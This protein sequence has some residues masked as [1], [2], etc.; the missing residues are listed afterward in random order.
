MARFLGNDTDAMG[1]GDREAD[2]LRIWIAYNEASNAGDHVTAARYIADDLAVMING[3]PA[4]ASAD[5][6][7]A[8]QAE[9]LRCY[10]DYT[11]DYLAGAVTPDGAVVEWCMHGTATADIGLPPLDVSGCSIVRCQDGRMVE[12]RLYHPTGV[13]DAVADQARARA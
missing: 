6:D 10:P 2:P 7:R 9:L 12:A 13:L 8:I 4:V 1:S 3:R 11:R 5:E